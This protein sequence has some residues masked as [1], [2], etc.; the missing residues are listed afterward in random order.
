MITCPICASHITTKWI[1]PRRKTLYHLCQSCE[2]IFM[3]PKDYPSK[4]IELK[5]YMEH[6]ND[7]SNEGYVNFL[8]N[9]ID[10]AVQPYLKSGHI[11]DYGSGPN[12]VLSILLER[13]GFHVAIYDPFFHKTMDESM[14]FD[15]ITATEVIEHFHDPMLNFKRMIEMLKPHGF[16]S[17]MTL[18]HHDDMDHFKDWFYQRD[19]THVIFYR[20]KTL[21][22]I[23][24]QLGLTLVEHNDYRY[25]VFK[26]NERGKL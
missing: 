24:D 25:A 15:M 4:E 22:I 9:F 13:R 8:E 6:E 18:F 23:A 20:P 11:L 19:P 14:T 3:D 1:H 16:L 21:S 2:A 12:P 26:K 17:V 5:K 10:S 7:L